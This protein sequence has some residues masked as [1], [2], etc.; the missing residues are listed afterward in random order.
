MRGRAFEVTV[1]VWL[2]CLTH[3]VCAEK[4]AL[5]CGNN[6]YPNFSREQW[7][8][9]CENDARLMHSWLVGKFAFKPDNVHMLL[10][11]QVTRANLLAELNDWLIGRSKPG[12]VL[13]FYWSGHGRQLPDDDGD[14]RD[15]DNLDEILVPYDFKGTSD[16][17]ATNY[18]RDD[19][20]NK[21]AQRGA[22]GRT[23]IAIVDACHSGTGL[24]NIGGGPKVKYLYYEKPATG[25]RTR[26][27]GLRDLFFEPYYIAPRSRGDEASA[28]FESPLRERGPTIPGVE[29]VALIAAARAN[30]RAAETREPVIVGD[31][32][33]THGFLTLELANAFRGDADTDGDGRITFDEMIAFLSKPI[34][35]EGNIQHPTVEISEAMRK[36]PLFERDMAAKV[37]P[38]ASQ[39]PAPPA[40][41]P[42]G[43][44]PLTVALAPFDSFP[45][46]CGE[47]DQTRTRELRRGIDELVASLE[48]SNVVKKVSESNPHEELILY[49]AR[50]TAGGV[51]HELAAS[52]S[53]GQFALREKYS[54]ADD[55]LANLRGELNRAYTVINLMKIRQ[56]PGSPDQLELTIEKSENLKRAVRPIRSGSRFRLNDKVY[57]RVCASRS[58]YL[59]M[60]SVTPDGRV[61]PIYPVFDED[62][63]R[64]APR[65]REG[66]IEGGKPIL[67]PQDGQ[68]I[69]FQIE[70]PIGVEFVKAFLTEHPTGIRANLKRKDTSGAAATG[71][72]FRSV[73]EGITGFR[74]GLPI[75][76]VDERGLRDD[77]E[78]KR[79]VRPVRRTP[80]QPPSPPEAEIDL[81]ALMRRT[82]A[83]ASFLFST[84]E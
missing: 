81:E 15:E 68:E 78:G 14:E 43:I 11:Q 56:P 83:D 63:P 80:P 84:T 32:K 28:G 37:A 60:I 49:G 55:S 18:I 10:N 59:T 22:Q 77:I 54:V 38:P 7:L 27:M 57:F 76:T 30:E 24:R 29:N 6:K 34:V 48:Q 16:E 9:G 71:G 39:P 40:F 74:G 52:D 53:S 3:G 46:L 61:E 67:L 17:N 25:P 47:L 64:A 70:R 26:G 19:E 79:Q 62:D 82:W 31:R 50:Q 23:F 65:D 73:M 44:Q 33:E 35:A 75:E 41:H 12:D 5:I 20:L 45:G 13:V 36:K 2:A 72:V 21:I 8:Q 4:Y 51:S 69:G 1:V 42:A 58:G 66:R